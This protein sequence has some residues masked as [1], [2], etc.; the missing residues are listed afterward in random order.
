MESVI[1]RKKQTKTSYATFLELVDL[2]F[3]NK[4]LEHNISLQKLR[5]ALNEA[6]R[7]LDTN[8]FARKSFFTDS[9]NIYLEIRKS[10]DKNG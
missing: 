8:H 4:F 6:S 3:V 10:T 5:K 2:I 9:R 1:R 7:L